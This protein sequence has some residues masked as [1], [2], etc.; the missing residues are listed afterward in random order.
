MALASTNLVSV[1]VGALTGLTLAAI[2]LRLAL[3]FRENRCL[4]G[5]LQRDA[6]TNL[7]NRSKLVFDLERVM[8]DDSGS[9]HALT[10]LDLDGFKS[11]NDTFGHP[12]GDALLTRLSGRLA[13]AVDGRGRAYRLGG[14]EFALLTPGSAAASKR[15]VR[16]AR[17][18]LSERGE[19]FLVTNSLGSAELPLEAASADHALQLADQRMYEDKDSR[20][21]TPGREVEAVLARVLQQRSP[22]LSEHGASVARLALAT[23]KWVGLPKAEQLALSRVAEFHDIGKVAIPDAILQKPGPLSEQEWELCASTR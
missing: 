9:P 13:A 16:A 4:V 17:E 8:H 10:I 23:A 19:G 6:L 20:R 1:V 5:A 21:P 22:A 2:V 7:G 3:T 18:A 15:I 11:Y 12:A 14:D